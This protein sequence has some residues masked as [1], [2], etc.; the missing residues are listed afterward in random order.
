MEQPAHARAV[1]RAQHVCGISICG[2]SDKAVRYQSIEAL[3]L[4]APMMHRLARMLC[5]QVGAKPQTHHSSAE[6]TEKL[7]VQIWFSP[8]ASVALASIGCT[9]TSASAASLASHS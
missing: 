3:R 7:Q 2:C 6:D 1:L 9:M 5:R 8:G 4:R